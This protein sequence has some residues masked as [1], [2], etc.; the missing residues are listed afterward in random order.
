MPNMNMEWKE[1]IRK[2]HKYPKKFSQNPTKEN[3]ELKNKIINRRT[4]QQNVGIQQS[5]NT[6]EGK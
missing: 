1:A 5:N 2:N 3:C 4:Q 6:G